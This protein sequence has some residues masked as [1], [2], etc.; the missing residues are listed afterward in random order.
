MKLKYGFAFIV[1]CLCS[2]SAF[3]YEF[4]TE[5][6]FIRGVVGPTINVVRY[7]LN[8]ADATPGA[9]LMIGVEAEY[10]VSKPWSL[11]GGFRPAFAPGFVDV[12]FGFG[13]KYRW[14]DFDIPINVSTGLELTPSILVPTSNVDSH[15]NLGL[16][17]SL[18][19]DY[20]VMSNIVLGAQVAFD[21]SILMNQSMRSFEASI[22]FLFG[23][24][25]KI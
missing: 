3:S 14:D 7:D 2:A 4:A 20:F 12:G 18:G 8:P 1:I 15:F 6:I 19:V 25:Y 9:G 17:A 5:K 10:V 11:I 13:G 22:E 16:R 24:M 21:P 23:V